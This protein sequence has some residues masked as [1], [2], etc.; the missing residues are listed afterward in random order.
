MI[1][2]LSNGLSLGFCQ[3]CLVSL[4][5]GKHQIDCQT[6]YLIFI[7]ALNAELSLIIILLINIAALTTF[8]FLILLP[9]KN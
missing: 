4:L 7:L 2:D 9:Y 8:P 3:C 6:V 1:L 5:P